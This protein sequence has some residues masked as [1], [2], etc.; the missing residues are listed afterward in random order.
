MSY[1]EDASVGEFGQVYVNS[2]TKS[3][4]A[5]IQGFQIITGTAIVTVAERNGTNS[6]SEIPPSDF[7]FPEGSNIVMNCKNITMVTTGL[8]IVNLAWSENEA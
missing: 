1:R 6:I 8:T 5:K 2:E 7:T 3:I 4:P